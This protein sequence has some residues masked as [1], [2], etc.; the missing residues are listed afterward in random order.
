MA[1]T[2]VSTGV[3]IAFA[4]TV[5]PAGWAFCDGRSVSKNDPMFQ[6]LFNVIGTIYGGDANPNFHLPD[7]RGYFLRGVDAGR[8][9]DPDA[10]SRKPSGGTPAPNQVGSIQSDAFASH[11][12][13]V[14]GFHLEADGGNGFDGTGLDTNSDRNGPF[15]HDVATS[16]Q[17]DSSET[18]PKNIYVN[19]IIAL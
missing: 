6:G 2:T 12:H 11:A 3:V 9:V 1:T 18:R 13:T 8:G 7:Y 4:G 15:Q 16:S 10:P 14:H 5:A 17:G 19:Y